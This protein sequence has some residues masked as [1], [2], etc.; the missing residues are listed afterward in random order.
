MM[1]GRYQDVAPCPSPVVLSPSPVVLSGAKDLSSSLRVN[2]AKDLGPS[3][4]GLRVNFAKEL[5]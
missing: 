1:N 4:D 3:A 5:L 2:S